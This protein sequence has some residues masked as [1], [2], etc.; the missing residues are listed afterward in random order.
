LPVG[1][2]DELLKKESFRYPIDA[3]H[4]RFSSNHDKN[5]QDGPAVDRYT[6]NGAR[7]AAVLTFTFPG[8][9]LIYNGQEVGNDKKLDLFDKVDIDWTKGND[10]REL[11]TTLSRVRREHPAL[12]DGGYERRWCSDTSRVYAFERNSGSDSVMVLI[13]FSRV[14]KKV[15]IAT[16]TVYTSILGSAPT[17]WKDGRM[18][19]RLEPYGFSLLV[20]A[21]KKER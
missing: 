14:R 20:P 15:T 1:V 12:S 16:S 21:S 7:A 19:V 8:V 13:N 5:V 4:L 11:Y 10:F 6:R 9:P 3:L 2:F 17:G 18:S